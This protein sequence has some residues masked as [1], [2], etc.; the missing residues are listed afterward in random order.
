MIMVEV[1]P[2][3]ARLANEIDATAESAPAAAARDAGRPACGDFDMRIGRDGT[4]YYRGSPIGRKELVKLFATVL[5]REED[6]SYWLVTPY[7]RGRI[8]VDDAPF[9][10]VELAV[11][12]EGRE[13]SLLF[14][15][16]LDERVAAGREHPIRL[17]YDAASGEPSPYILVRPGLEAL[18]LRPVYYQLVE[19]GAIE[20]WEEG[21]LLGIWS[22]G[23]L[24]SLGRLDAKR[25]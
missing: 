2:D 5:R 11:E 18:I 24:F 22:G 14:R 20:E 23:V 9:T 1:S 6:G 17:S 25:G 10:A 8:A 21:G 19:L 4:W 16:N 12:G 3:K 7:E 13:Q 15:T